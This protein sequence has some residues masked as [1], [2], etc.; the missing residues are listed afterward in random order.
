MGGREVAGNL[1]HDDGARTGRRKGPS[2]GERKREFQASCFVASWER[3]QGRRGMG[4]KRETTT[5]WRLK[6]SD[7]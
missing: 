5:W 7:E 1:G 3:E 6:K 4:T 2:P